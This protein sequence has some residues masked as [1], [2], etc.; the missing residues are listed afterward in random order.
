MTAWLKHVKA[1]KAANSGKSLK[2]VL[3]MASKTYKRVGGGNLSPL[4]LNGNVKDH[5]DGMNHDGG[6]EMNGDGRNAEGGNGNSNMSGGK[7]KNRRNK[8]GGFG[9]QN[10]PVQ[11]VPCPLVGEEQ[12]QQE[13]WTG[14]KETDADG[15]EKCVAAEGGQQNG[16]RRRRNRSKKNR[17]NKNRNNK[18][19]N[20]RKNRRGGRRTNK[21]QK[22]RRN[23]SQRI[24]L[25]K[26]NPYMKKHTLHRELKK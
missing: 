4:S 11:P 10:A 22:N 25:M 6:A 2:E 26:Y 15:V 7:R 13:E 3:Q 16:G 23:N 18:N 24:E 17:N 1:V 14:V 19:R 12:K 20:T 21:N 8:K 9:N 5:K